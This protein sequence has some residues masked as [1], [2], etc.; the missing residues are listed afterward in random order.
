MPA[1]F[2]GLD[3]KSLAFHCVVID[4]IFLSKDFSYE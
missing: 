4:V 3:G 1:S 2:K